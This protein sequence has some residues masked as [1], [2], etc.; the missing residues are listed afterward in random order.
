MAVR[1][2]DN[3]SY[4]FVKL[5]LGKLVFSETVWVFTPPPLLNLEAT[6]LVMIVTLN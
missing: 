5:F 4:L 1:G 2:E 3:A 6:S